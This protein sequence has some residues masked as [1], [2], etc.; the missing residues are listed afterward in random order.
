MDIYEQLRM[1][2]DSH[3]ST[4]PEGDAIH[5]ILRLLFTPEEAAVAVCMSFKPK[6]PADLARSAGIDETAA[7]LHLESMADKGVIF[8]KNQSGKKRYG[9]VPLIPGVF[10]FPFMK[11]G[12]TPMHDR[13]AKLWE[14]YH[15]ESLGASFAGNPTP[16]MRVVAV[17][18]SV[19]PEQQFHPYDEV[20]RLIENAGYVALTRCACRISVAQCDK[21][22]EVCL[23]F[24]GVGE[25]LVERGFARQISKAE[26]IRVL[27]QAEEAGLVHTSN[28]SADKASVI[29]NC[30]PCCCVFLRAITAHGME[31]VVASSRYRATIDGALC[32]R[33]GTCVGRCPLHSITIGEQCACVDEQRCLGCGLCATACPAGA[34]RLVPVDNISPV[35]HRV[36]GF[37]TLLAPGQRP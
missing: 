26:G 30:C 4:A 32:A 17:E 36:S 10:E 5:E 29:C 31:H 7:T 24:D 1:I 33:C 25:F 19:T 20:R 21:P 18:K 14:A 2:L 11:G 13:L 37:E 23:I 8:S 34:I 16:M 27:D 35:P 15:A 6:S 3:P 28:N 22:K 9:L 12:G